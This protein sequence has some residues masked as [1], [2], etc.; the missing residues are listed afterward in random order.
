MDEA[1]FSIVVT[2]ASGFVG[3]RITAQL[4]SHYGNDAVVACDRTESPDSIRLDM[5][6]AESVRSLIKA[7]RPSVVIHLAAVSSVPAA[8]DDPR[9]TWRTNVMGT[10]ELILAISCYAPACHLLYV[11][12]AEVYGRSAF[13][14]RPVD[15]ATL[16]QPANP[17]AASK[18]AADIM[19][20]EAAGRGLKATIVRPFNHTGPGQSDDFVVPAFCRQ[21]ARIE[22]GLQDPV[23]HVGEL[24]DER[25]FLD[26]D[27]VVALYST[28][29]ARGDSLQPGLVLNASSGRSTRIADILDWLLG[30]AR[31]P[32][33]V[34]I[35]TAKLRATR[36]PRI[37]G[38]ATKA[39]ATVGWMPL[40]PLE[41]T[42]GE[43]L[44][45]WRQKV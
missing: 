17:Y 34:E 1:G 37:V 42:L 39:H 21:I 5:N 25:D 8:F 10:Q 33:Q 27:D 13:S 36:V 19:V 40:K 3:A 6:D 28:I 35:D 4:R 29:V 20:Q 38:D 9:S 12:S 2:G 16:L 23:L 24:R 22:K 45:W 11:S 18:A 32:I 30:Q 15:E 26:V 41:Q 44:A 43:T 31:I 14:G 7:K